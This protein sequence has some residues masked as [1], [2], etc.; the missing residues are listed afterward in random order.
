[1]EHL[2]CALAQPTGMIGAPPAFWHSL[3]HST[4]SGTGVKQVRLAVAPYAPHGEGE[5]PSPVTLAESLSHCVSVSLAT[6]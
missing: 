4:D 2:L 5:A 6:K 1:M 3:S